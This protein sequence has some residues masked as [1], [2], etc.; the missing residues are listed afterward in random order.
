MAG[1]RKKGRCPKGSSIEQETG[2][3]SSVQSDGFEKD[4]GSGGTGEVMDERASELTEIGDEV[5]ERSGSQLESDEDGG[6]RGAEVGGD[7]EFVRVEYVKGR[8]RT[9]P[10]A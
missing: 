9:G 5:N 3:G 1:G 10:D 6:R 2:G 8:R 4:S 7:G